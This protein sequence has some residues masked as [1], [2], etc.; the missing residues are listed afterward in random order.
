[1]SFGV[2]GAPDLTLSS[3]IPIFQILSMP[4]KPDHREVCGRWD[5]G[6]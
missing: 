6:S 4:A 3:S 2:A 1:M 5:Y